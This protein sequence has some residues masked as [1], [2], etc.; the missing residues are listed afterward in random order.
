MY[1]NHHSFVWEYGT[2]LV[3]L[4]DPKPEDFILDVGCG[5]GELTGMIAE[6]GADVVGIDADPEMVENAILNF[7]HID[8]P[9]VDASKLLGNQEM[10]SMV[11]IRRFDAIFSNA[12]LHWVTDAEDAVIGMASLLKDGGRFV[13]EFGGKGNVEQI[14]QAALEVVREK[15]S[16]A[17]N[18]KNNNDDNVANPWYFPTIAEYSSLLEK[19]GIEVTSAVLYDRPTLLQDGENGMKHWLE[20]FGNVLFKDIPESEKDTTIDAVVE[21]LRRTTNL[22]DSKERQWTAD[23]RRI[24][25]VGKKITHNG[26]SS[27]N[28]TSTPDWS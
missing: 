2:S 13:V 27:K 11:V 15:K 23:Y 1:Q 9:C 16:S 24:R 18:N 6:K 17:S 5:S 25:I 12:A 7:P 14:V 8:F 28:D 19:H 21:R 3:D 20:M 10:A 26:S 22:Y 4:L